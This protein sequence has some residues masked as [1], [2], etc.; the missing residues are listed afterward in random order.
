MH[1]AGAGNFYNFMMSS[2]GESIFFLRAWGIKKLDPRAKLAVEPKLAHFWA[3][4]FA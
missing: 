3:N 2:D 4:F 1:I